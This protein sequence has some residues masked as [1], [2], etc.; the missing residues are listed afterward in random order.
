GCVVP[1]G[2]IVVDEAAH[3]QAL[4]QDRAHGGG[5][6]VDAVAWTGGVVLGDEPGD[7]DSREVVEQRQH[8]LPDRPPDVLEVDVDA[9]WAGRRQLRGEIGA[10]VIDRRVEAEFVLHV[11]V[12]LGTSRDADRPG[13]GELGA[14]TDQRPDRSARRRDNDGFAGLGLADY[15]Q[16]A[17]GGEAGDPQ[18]GEARRYWG[19]G[20][21]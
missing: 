21:V 8:R 20:A 17:V 16:A 4:R 12:L 11:R 5:Q 9:V 3:R 18:G 14:L 1:R 2:K 15:A 13:A 19:A 7:R 10:L 6:P